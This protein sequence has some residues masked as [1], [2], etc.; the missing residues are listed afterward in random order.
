M[1]M[2][3]IYIYHLFIIFIAQGF[4]FSRF[5]FYVVVRIITGMVNII[6]IIYYDD[7]FSFLFFKINK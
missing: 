2:G 1:M 4:I 5:C 7:V 6:I 3:F